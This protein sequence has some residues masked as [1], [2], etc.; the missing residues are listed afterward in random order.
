MG[1]S[2]VGNHSNEIKNSLQVLNIKHEMTEESI[3]QQKA[4]N[5]NYPIWRIEKEKN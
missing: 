4:I 2:G 5:I 3:G 1:N